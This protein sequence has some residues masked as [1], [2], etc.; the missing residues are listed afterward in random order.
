MTA[1]VVVPAALCGL[2]LM[3]GAFAGFRASAGRQ[4]RLPDVR[5]NLRS[6]VVG[7]LA[8][9]TALVVIGGSTVPW[10]APAADRAVRYDEYVRAGT[11]MLAVYVPM[12]VVTLIA[13]ALHLAGPSHEARAAAMTVVLG[14]VTLLRPAVIVLGSVVAG[15]VENR[16]NIWFAAAVAASTTIMAGP[17]IGAARFPAVDQSRR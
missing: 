10:L 6:G 7:V 1:S 2:A 11:A 3:D 4:A 9:L 17:L 13:I 5:A 8:A 16:P 15:L 14:P 12:A